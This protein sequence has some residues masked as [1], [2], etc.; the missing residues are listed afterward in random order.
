M[1]SGILGTVGCISLSLLSFTMGLDT[2]M[3]NHG[4]AGLRVVP[5]NFTTMTLHDSKSLLEPQLFD[6]GSPYHNGFSGLG[7]FAKRQ[8]CDTG[9]ASCR[10]DV[11]T[12]C[13][14]RGDCCGGGLCCGAGSFCYAG[15]C[16]AAD[17]VGCD[18]KVGRCYLFLLF[19]RLVIF[20]L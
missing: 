10:N 15:G 5:G 6:F 7:R 1:R 20:C 9:F 3:P 11:N 4:V 19:D 14:I 2:L 17:K 18:N 16:C 13:E 8:S 12:C